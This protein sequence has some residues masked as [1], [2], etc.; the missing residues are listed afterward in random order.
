MYPFLKHI[1]F[2]KLIILTPPSKHHLAHCQHLMME[3][4]KLF[5]TK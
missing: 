1:L 4:E 5:F 2:I 3:L